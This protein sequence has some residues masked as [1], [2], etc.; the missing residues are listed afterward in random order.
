ME[1]AGLKFELDL[2]PLPSARVFVDQEMWEKIVFNLLSNAFKFTLTGGVKVTLGAKGREAVLMVGDTGIGIPPEELG[3]VFKR[4]HRI[5]GRRGRTHEGTGIGLALVQELVKLHAGT[6]CV[7]SEP[8]GGTTFEVRL[9]FGKEH[10]PKDRVESAPTRQ[11]IAPAGEAFVEEAL[12]WVPEPLPSRREG[13]ETAPGQKFFARPR[14][15]FAEDNADMRFYVHRLLQAD[16]A[17]EAVADGAAAL[18]AA[19]RNPPD[20]I[21]SDV[22]MPHMNG[23]ELV[24]AVRADDNLR[25]TPIILLSAR[26]GEEAQLESASQLA[27]DYLIKPFSARELLARVGVHVKLARARAGRE[28]EL[29]K[30]ELKL[31]ESERRY[32]SLFESIDEGFC[33]IEMLFDQD[34]KAVDYRFVEVNPAFENQTGMRGATGRRMLEFVSSIEPH[35]LENYGR[36]A[37]TGESIRF[38]AEYKSLLRW[39]DVFA[40][41]VGD[42]RERKVAVL[43]NNITGRRRAEEA[44]QTEIAARKRVTEELQKAQKELSHHAEDLEQQVA[45][46]TESLREALN[47]LEEF[48]YSVS[49]DLRAPLRAIEGYSRI[50][51]EDYGEALPAGAHTYLDK[52]SRSAERME[53]LVNDVLTL[54][55]VARADLQ[56]RP[57]RLQQFIEELVEQHPFTQSPAPEITIAAPHTV[58]GDEAR[59]GQAI[60][61]LIGNAVKFVAP[62]EKA[63]V[64]VRSELLGNR[65]RLWV[66]DEGIGI[67]P[68]HRGKL[69]GMFQRLPANR[70]YEGTGIGLAIV[71][72]AV[73]VMGGSV[74][75]ESNESKGSRFWIELGKD[76]T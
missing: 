31:H 57:I 62:G 44:A 40:F 55:R 73:E 45:T 11:H 10:L 68:Q 67:P 20:L 41:R 75:M 61:N 9:P 69:F 29:R 42:P 6:I 49:H 46:R 5:E 59:L 65:V 58:M 54:S 34:Q 48:S 64:R 35:W 36:V 23:F 21:L 30:S 4:F 38:A 76:Q 37:L 39:F 71:R 15:V 74:G 70:P 22:M 13:A 3:N 1:R 56:L 26:A 43:F 7:R 2:R 51:R 53:R 50:F 33:V 60:S 32:R 16:Y 14:I 47:Q 63:V 52:I 18:E 17:V 28:S 24:Q 25:S 27:D 66:E 72:K 12:T 8:G 19:R